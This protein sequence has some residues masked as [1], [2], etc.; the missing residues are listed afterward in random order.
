MQ[1]T[2]FGKIW[3]AAAA[4]MAAIPATRSDVS[5]TSGPT[6]SVACRLVGCSDGTKKCAD[7]HGELSD[8]LIGKFSVTWYCYEPSGPGDD[9]ENSG[10]EAVL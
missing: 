10:E 6:K 2:R 4:V 7:V 5:A 1:R 3:L 8:P 9:G